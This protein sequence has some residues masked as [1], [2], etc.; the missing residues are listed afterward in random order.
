MICYSSLLLQEHSLQQ[1]VRGCDAVAKL[2]GGKMGVR[3]GE[4]IGQC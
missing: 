3:T 2:V 1:K 4:A